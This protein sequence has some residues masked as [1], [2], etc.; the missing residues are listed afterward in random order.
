M[1]TSSDSIAARTYRQVNIQRDTAK[2]SNQNLLNEKTTVLIFLIKIKTVPT[3]WDTQSNE[4]TLE[5]TIDFANAQEMIT[6]AILTFQADKFLARF[7]RYVPTPERRPNWKL[8][9]CLAEIP[10]ASLHM[11]KDYSLHASFKYEKHHLQHTMKVTKHFEKTN[12]I[13][14][15]LSVNHTQKGIGC[16]HQQVCR[17]NTPRMLLHLCG[18][19]RLRQKQFCQMIMTEQ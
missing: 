13:K 2:P 1:Y 11:H 10:N 12:T 8:H 5:A 18:D 9:Q 7:N 15:S 16:P 4:Q 17:I 3:P 19:H 14:K 6:S